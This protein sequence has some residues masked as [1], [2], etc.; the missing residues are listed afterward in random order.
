M[1]VS[2]FFASLAHLSK[3]ET[4]ALALPVQR[5][6]LGDPKALGRFLRRQGG[7]I[8]CLRIRATQHDAGS[9][10]LSQAM[11]WRSVGTPDPW[12]L[13][14]WI[15]TALGSDIWSDGDEPQHSEE[16]EEEWKEYD[17][18]ALEALEVSSNLIPLETALYLAERF[19]G[20]VKSLGVLGSI[21]SFEFVKELIKVL[22]RSAARQQTSEECCT[23]IDL[24]G[25]AETVWQWLT[26]APSSSS[27]SLPSTDRWNRNLRT[28]KLGPVQ[29]SPELLD[30]L[31]NNLP[32]LQ[33]LELIVK[34]FLPSQDDVVIYSAS[35][36]KHG[37]GP[38]SNVGG[39][40]EGDG[41]QLDEQ[42]VCHYYYFLG[43][44]LNMMIV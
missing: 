38:S 13:N 30:L 20:R 18:E 32:N 6:H 44:L 43:I 35:R 37:T 5:P 19:G 41:V 8:K 2:P 40:A 28:L 24:G 22:G 16:E 9:G 10:S 26:P 23:P 7:T 27:S 3:L 42:V 17:L 25:D 36:A 4:L 34:H 1:D 11:S 21:K 14:E 39:G 31:A 15:R 33:H 29:L 12:S